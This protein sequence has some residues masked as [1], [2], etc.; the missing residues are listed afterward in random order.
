M[1]SLVRGPAAGLVTVSAA[2]VLVSCG[3]APEQAPDMGGTARGGSVPSAVPGGRE[4][5][6]SLLKD[7]PGPEEALTPPSPTTSPRP[8]RPATWENSPAPSS[9][10]RARSDDPAPRPAGKP[11]RP[12]APPPAE[13]TLPADAGVVCAMGDG[14]MSR[15][16]AALCQDA[17][18]R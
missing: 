9:N 13:P 10:T 8:R 17:L 12:A 7:A 5:P 6:S 3:P 15:D 11:S 18:G 14:Y 2:V 16:L 4:P 1:R